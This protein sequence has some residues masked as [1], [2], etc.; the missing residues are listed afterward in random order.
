[1]SRR[2]S[3]S[4]RSWLVA[5]L[6]GLGTLVATGAVQGTS[7][8]KQKLL[9]EDAPSIAANQRVGLPGKESLLPGN[10]RHTSHALPRTSTP[11][12]LLRAAWLIA[13]EFT[14]S[15]TSSE[16]AESIGTSQRITGPSR[17]PPAA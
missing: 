13:P 15:V 9:R 1:M 10:V 3:I 12:P 6:F 7:A 8:A 2:R 4:F 16:I 5:T 17:A 11:A 14:A